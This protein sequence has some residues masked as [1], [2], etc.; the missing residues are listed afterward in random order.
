M[1]FDE[2]KIYFELYDCTFLLFHFTRASLLVSEGNKKLLQRLVI[3]LR[4][5]SAFEFQLSNINIHSYHP[6]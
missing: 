4:V 5:L 3:P 2:K 1:L 6:Y